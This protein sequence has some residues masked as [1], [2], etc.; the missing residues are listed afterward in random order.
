MTEANLQLIEPLTLEEEVR[1]RLLLAQLP[2]PHVR[3][4]VRTKARVSLRRLGREIGVT[5]GSIYYYER[6]GDP[7]IAVAIRYRAE[8]EKLARLIG[9]DLWAETRTASP[10]GK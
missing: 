6:G 3:K 2:S 8:L 10:A 1:Q 7:G 4:T 9:F 5:H